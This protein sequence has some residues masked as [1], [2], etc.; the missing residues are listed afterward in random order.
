MSMT[1]MSDAG[2]RQRRRAAEKAKQERYDRE[3]RLVSEGNAVTKRAD[4]LA[5]RIVLGTASDDEIRAMLNEGA[6]TTNPF[7]NVESVRTACMTAGR[8]D[9]L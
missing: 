7:V 9:L 4:E 2:R 6:T 5:T 3:D 8:W 1:D